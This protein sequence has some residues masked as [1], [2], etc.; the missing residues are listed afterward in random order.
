MGKALSM[1][2]GKE[3][4]AISSFKNGIYLKPS[5]PEGIYHLAMLYIKRGN[6]QKALGVLKDGME[7][8][9]DSRIGLL[10]SRTLFDLRMFKDAINIADDVLAKDPNVSDAWLVM[11]RSYGALHKVEEYKQC[12]RKYLHMKPDDAKVKM[13]MEDLDR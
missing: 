3:E 8:A 13:E 4:K 11:G 5:D 1:I 2:P 10:L 6:R 7:R 12:L 9:P